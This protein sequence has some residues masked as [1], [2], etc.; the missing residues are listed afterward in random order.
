MLSIVRANQRALKSCGAQQNKLFI[1]EEQQK[2]AEKQRH[3]IIEQEKTNILKPGDR[4]IKSLRINKSF[5]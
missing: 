1:I 4:N 2:N 5:F 3:S